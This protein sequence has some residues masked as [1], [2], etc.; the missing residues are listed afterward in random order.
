MQPTALA[1]LER[2]AWK[3]GPANPRVFE[4]HR[5]AGSAA[6]AYPGDPHCHRGACV[7]PRRS[8]RRNAREPTC[9]LPH[10]GRPISRGAELGEANFSG[11]D[12]ENI[13]LQNAQ[14]L[15]AKLENANLRGARLN[16]AYLRGAALLGANLSFANLNK[17]DLKGARL[18][19]ASLFG[20]N[21]A[22]AD[23]GAA[24]LTRVNLRSSLLDKATVLDP[25]W[26]LVWESQNRAATA[27]FCKGPTFPAHSCKRRTCGAP[28]CRGRPAGRRPDRGRSD[29]RRFAAGRAANRGPQRHDQNRP[30][31]AP[32]L[33]DS[34]S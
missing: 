30:E 11:A 7:P 1:H 21:L 6:G 4:D 15:F 3:P 31:V 19:G 18:R 29:G 23:L 22:G 27:A 9:V 26:R 20:A 25:K 13:D 34:E 12:L 17:A 8:A 28:I 33:G 32:G 5:L 24:D 10:V 14:M 16:G 2:M